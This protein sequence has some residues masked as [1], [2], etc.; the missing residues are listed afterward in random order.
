MI[1][2]SRFWILDRG[3]KQHESH[4]RKR[5]R[6]ERG[7]SSIAF[8]RG[9]GRG[10]PLFGIWEKWMAPNVDWLRQC[11]RAGLYE[12]G[13]AI[14]EKGGLNLANLTDEQQIEAED[15]YRLCVRR[16]SDEETKPKKRQRKIK[17]DDEQ[18]EES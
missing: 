5:L 11:R 7:S 9:S 13:K 2:D 3:L 8:M 4:C 16:G 1:L 18:E 17:P 14:Y 15:D 12:L 6:G 10:R